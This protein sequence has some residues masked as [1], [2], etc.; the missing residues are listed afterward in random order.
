MDNIEQYDGEYDGG[1]AGDDSDSSDDGMVVT[2]S[3]IQIEAILRSLI[4]EIHYVRRER[5]TLSIEPALFRT[6]ITIA[7]AFRNK[8]AIVDDFINTIVFT[9]FSLDI[10]SH[11]YMTLIWSNAETLYIQELLRQ[12]VPPR[13]SVEIFAALNTESKD[14][15]RERMITV[16]PCYSTL[17]WLIVAKRISVFYPVKADSSHA[18]TGGEYR[19]FPT[20]VA[21]RIARDVYST[22]DDRNLWM[23]G[24]PE[25]FRN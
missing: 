12:K 15:L 17:A 9:R 4:D 2:N 19:P 10:S 22:R 8:L 6:I 20:D 14:V 3:D 7:F 24:I 25:E 18:Q 11:V 23:G 13:C 5:V 16:A 1:R 21:L